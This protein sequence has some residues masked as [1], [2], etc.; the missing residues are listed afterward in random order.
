MEQ[1]SAPALVSIGR[2]DCGSATQV[3]RVLLKEL[4]LT[5]SAK[6]LLSAAK[7]LTDLGHVGTP[8]VGPVSYLAT[9][10]SRGES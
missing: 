5:K 10:T 2:P 9:S 4:L 8:E 7:S 1:A 3:C 6:N